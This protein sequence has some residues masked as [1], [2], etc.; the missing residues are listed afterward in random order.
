MSIGNINQNLPI[1]KLPLEEEP[2][3]EPRQE[4]WGQGTENHPSDNHD[5]FAASDPDVDESR[6]ARRHDDQEEE[7]RHLVKTEKN[8]WESARRIDKVDHA[9][10][11]KI[12]ARA[13][14]LKQLP[15]AHP[16]TP[17]HAGDDG[18]AGHHVAA[19][20]KQHSGTG[21]QPKLSTP[22]TRLHFS[23]ARPTDQQRLIKTR[24][25]GGLRRSEQLPR[26]HDDDEASQA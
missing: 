21:V 20:D 25:K 15:Q 23:V 10:I 3:A 19:L 26:S 22:S 24:S 9:Q 5:S 8:K 13:D 18:F 11:T 7:V 12:R 17:A 14:V 1:N 4:L 16:Q 6:L 2:E